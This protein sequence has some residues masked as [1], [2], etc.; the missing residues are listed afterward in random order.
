MVGI[1][2]SGPDEITTPIEAARKDRGASM[3]VHTLARIEIRPIAEMRRLHA[4]SGKGYARLLR[5]LGES[6]S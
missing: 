3:T 5:K 6:N 4:H 2:R 1:R